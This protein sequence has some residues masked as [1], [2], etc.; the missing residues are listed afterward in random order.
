VG[1]NI[2]GRDGNT[3]K[4]DTG[5]TGLASLTGPK[6]RLDFYGSYFYAQSNNVRTDDNVKIGMRYTNYLSEKI[7]WFVRSEGERDT[8]ANIQFRS[9]S[10]FGL[11]YRW[12][13]EPKMELEST[14][15]LSYRYE[16]YT[17]NTPS[18]GFPGLDI[19]ARFIWE[20]STWGK[21]SSIIS[22][23]PS[24]DDFGDFILKQD[25]AVEVPLANS[26]RWKLRFGLTNEYNSAPNQGRE[27]LDSLY[28]LRLV[29]S[30]K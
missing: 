21:L 29:L 28:Y 8:F 18:E 15:G 14:L 27:K 19:G 24:I 7:G 25:T 3:D 30:W 11:S 23:L 26:E 12:I 17:T 1:I 16:D 2:A 5:L 10:A 13:K 9:T 4:F 22:Y 6:D 20:F